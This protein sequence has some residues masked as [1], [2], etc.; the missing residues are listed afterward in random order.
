MG[1]Q[2]RPQIRSKC[3]QQ[4]K[5]HLTYTRRKENRETDPERD[6]KY[7]GQ[8]N[9]S[10]KKKRDKLRAARLG[11]PE[12][13]TFPSS[14]TN[15]ELYEMMLL[16]EKLHPSTR[17]EHG[18]KVFRKL[19]QMPLESLPT[20]KVKFSKLPT[21]AHLLR[22]LFADNEVQYRS[23][24]TG[25]DGGGRE[26][27]LAGWVALADNPGANIND[28]IQVPYFA[29]GV[30]ASANGL[31]D[32]GFE[33]PECLRRSDVYVSPVTH[34][35]ELRLE[36]R[37]DPP[38]FHS[39]ITP[40]G[41]ISDIHDDSVISTSMLVQLYGYKVLLSWPGTQT[42]REYFKDCHGTDHDLRL[43]EA[44]ERMPEGFKVTILK[45]CVGV[46]LD[47]GMIHAVM[48]PTNSAIGCWEYVD[49]QWLDGEEIKQGGLWE[50][51]LIKKRAGAEL[52][53]DQKAK[54]MYRQLRYGVSMWKCLEK[55]LVD[56]GG[57]EMRGRVK[58]IESLVACLEQKIPRGNRRN[59]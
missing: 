3:P 42:N 51:G 4:T 56:D 53:T 10:A 35:E 16:W 41:N 31:L 58:Q 1:I 57:E 36:S 44:I 40:A 21:S 23:C 39:I 2:N 38:L 48:S 13:T 29:V 45:P 32:C 52:P 33:L 6:A 47:P 43:F 20:F 49:A 55:T 14:P 46:K 12:I 37:K 22:Y 25:K 19:A 59:A 18:L 7:K 26:D 54:D 27:F 9:A 24:L 50:L 28:R 17:Q 11:D 5:G 34:G 8:H 15:L 30:E